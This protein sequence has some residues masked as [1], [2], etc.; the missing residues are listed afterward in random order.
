MSGRS[1]ALA[2]CAALAALSPF[3]GIPGWTVSL[4]TVAALTALG[5]IGLNLIFGVVGMLA[6]GQAAFMALPG[7]IGGVLEK[8]G[9]PLVLALAVGLVATLVIAQAVAQLFVRLPGVFLAIGTLAFGF[10]VEGLARAFPAWTG[11]ASGLIFVFGRQLD[12]LL[13]YVAALAALA[14]GLALYAGLVRGASWRRLRTIRH[15]ELAAAVL[16]IDVAREKA[17]AYAIGSGFAAAAGIL[18]TGYVGVLIPENAGVTRSLEQVGTVL[19]GGLG[20]LAGPVVGSVIVQWLFVVSA[21]GQKY[22]LLIYGVAFLGAV[23]YAPQGIVGLVVRLPL[24]RAPDKATAT[25]ALPATHA[26]LPPERAAAPDGVSLSV[27]QAAKHYGGVVAVE[28]I[29]FEVRHGEVFAIVGPNGAGKTTLFN[30]ISGVE[31]PT[32]GRIAVE[33]RDLADVPIDRRAPLMGRSFQV[34]RLVPELTA[35]ENVMVRLDQIAPALSED[36]RAGTALAQLTLF[37]LQHLAF[38]PV[39]ELS[40]GQHKLIDLARAA[41]GD[42]PLVL[43]DEPAVGLTRGELDHLAELL[44]RL[45]RRGSAVVIVEHN[46]DFVASVATRGIVL[47]SGRTIAYGRVDEILADPR[48]REAYFG[49]LT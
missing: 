18:L 9:L 12:P 36:E 21:Y 32:S 49:V 44:A 23:L 47:D 33:G 30:L 41:V 20:T 26:A 27:A 8:L 6:F 14:L 3:F 24:L 48:V 38:R 22:E 25:I 31:R 11:G 45:K 40:L 7:Y 29:S 34:A 42:P 19:L 39:R 46:I 13:W 17:R 28:G 1:L 15:D 37:D 4:A 43:L 35:L 2:L 5:L 16:G 10:V